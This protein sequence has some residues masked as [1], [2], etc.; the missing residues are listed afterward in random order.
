MKIY[1][2]ALPAIPVL[3]EAIFTY[4]FGSNFNRYQPNGRAYVDAATG[5][6]ISR[7]QTRDLS[8]AFAHG[9]RHGLA[10]QGGMSLS[11][12]DVVMIISPNSIAWPVM[13]FGIWAAGLRA[14]LANSSYTPREVVHQWHDSGAKAIIV[15]P[16]L[17]EVVLEAFKIMDVD[18]T[19]ARRRIVVADW[20]IN[21]SPVG[22]QDYVLVSDLLKNGTL[23]EE[24]KFVGQ[25][26]HETTLLCYSSGTTGKPKGVEVSAC[27]LLTVPK[28]ADNCVQTTHQ[29]LITALE[30]FTAIWPRVAD[31][32]DNVM[33]G[34]LPFYH[35]YG[36]SK[37]TRHIIEYHWQLTL[38][39]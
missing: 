23:S 28:V 29:N 16:K 32:G 12:G 30:M 5:F 37:T 36:E 27:R 10:R 33:L 15:H 2:S 21:H 14:T 38:L 4:L 8:L 11:R 25:Q 24:E 17:L 13:L 31:Q 20:G 35:I 9:L 18:F 1:T 6:A 3:H 19:E 22:L 34:V 39:L 7:A 26:A